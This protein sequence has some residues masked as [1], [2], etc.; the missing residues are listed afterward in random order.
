MDAVQS[1]VEKQMQDQVNYRSQIR[2]REV[3]IEKRERELYTVLWSIRQ[4]QGDSSM[5]SW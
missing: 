4:Q 1:I 3:A 2:Q 5:R